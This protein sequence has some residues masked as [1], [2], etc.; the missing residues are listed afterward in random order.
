MDCS[1]GQ[2]RTGIVS[3][4]EASLTSPAIVPRSATRGRS[5][6]QLERSSMNKRRKRHSASEGEAYIEAAGMV[7]HEVTLRGMIEDG[8]LVL[9]EY[10]EEHSV[11]L[12]VSGGGESLLSELLESMGGLPAPDDDL[13]W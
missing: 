10:H 11:S 1:D 8:E 2:E 6:N 3:P 12:R 4:S 5:I 9:A 7:R 13:I